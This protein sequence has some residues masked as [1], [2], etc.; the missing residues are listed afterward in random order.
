MTISVQVYDQRSC[1]LGEGPLW[2]PQR[3]QLFW[4]DIIAKRLLS[5]EGGHSLQWQFDEHFSAA[6]WIDKH[7]LLL[8]SESGLWHFDIASAKRELLCPIEQDNLL[9]RSNDGRA[10]PF[11]GFWISTMAKNKAYA[12]GAIYR[13][14]K[15]ELRQLFSQITIPNSIC[16]S[17]DGSCA[18]FCDTVKQKI[19]RQG[20]DDT[21][22]PIGEPALFVDLQ[23]EGLFPDGS[24]VDE[25]GALWNAQWGVGRVAQYLP[26]G[27]LGSIV[28]TPGLQS[29]CPA[30]GGSELQT[31]FVT[32]A[33]ED[34][35]EP[36]VYQGQ[37]YC[38]DLSI[39]GQSEPQVLL[40]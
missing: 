33:L 22:W 30:F 9:T 4:F 14:Y 10:D 7:S 13:F 23:P 24:V 5:R 29:S 34:L 21:G 16:F 40:A 18:Y 25:S 20:L 26:D 27:R 36:D 6:G 2:H 39:R 12:K 37:L 19:M 32:T 1:E 28:N 3:K 11:G 17:P 8:A 38:A 35:S 15:G 31:L